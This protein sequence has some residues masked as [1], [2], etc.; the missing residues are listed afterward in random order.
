MDAADK[1]RLAKREG[2]Y[3]EIKVQALLVGGGDV[4]PQLAFT[5]VAKDRCRK[6][7]G[8]SE[9]YFSLVATGA[10]ECDLP[11]AYREELAALYP[12]PQSR[13]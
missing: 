3:K 9:E 6:E 11:V 8:P 4:T 10:E 5:F 1:A 12:S 7:C 2:G 13:Y